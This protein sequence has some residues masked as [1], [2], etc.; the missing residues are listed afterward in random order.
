MKIFGFHYTAIFG[1]VFSFVVV[2]IVHSSLCLISHM[3]RSWFGFV[4]PEIGIILEN[5]SSYHFIIFSYLQCELMDEGWNDVK[6]REA[7][8]ILNLAKVRMKN[9]IDLL[10][11]LTLV[12]MK[13]I[14]QSNHASCYL[15]S[16]ISPYFL[17]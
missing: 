7:T 6:Y 17:R 13:I 1:A 3:G 4:Q 15:Y 16:S 9:K 12:D 8:C 10:L 5:T 14:S 11:T 2:N